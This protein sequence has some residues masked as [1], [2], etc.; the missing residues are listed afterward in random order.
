MAGSVAEDKEMMDTNIEDVRKLQAVLEQE[1]EQVQED[2]DL[3]FNISDEDEESDGYESDSSLTTIEN[4]SE[5]KLHLAEEEYLAVDCLKISK[6]FNVIKPH[7]SSEE[8]NVINSCKNPKLKHLLVLNRAKNINLKSIL[9]KLY[10]SYKEVLGHITKL[11]EEAR[12][13]REEKQLY[14]GVPKNRMHHPYFYKSGMKYSC[15]LNED[16]KRRKITNHYL[17]NSS[18]RW[19]VQDQTI[20]KRAV[21]FQYNQYQ[22]KETNK[23]ISDLLRVKKEYKGSDV[24]KI[25]EKIND[26]KKEVETLKQN[27]NVSVPDLKNGIIDWLLISTQDLAGKHSSHGC[28]GMWNMFLHP[29][30]NKS[31]KWTDSENK[32]LNELA[33]AH[34]FQDW[35]TIAKELGTNRSAYTVCIQFREK[36]MNSVDVGRFDVDEDTQLIRAVNAYRIGNYIPWTKVAE[37]FSNRLKKQLYNRY[38]VY[39]NKTKC[40]KRGPFTLEEDILLLILVRKFGANYNTI[41]EYIPYR[42][43]IQVSYRYTSYLNYSVMK[44]GSWSLLEDNAIMQHVK[45]HGPKKWQL[46]V[47]EVP[48][49]NAAHF[50]H[51]YHHLNKWLESNKNKTIE[52]IPR[53]DETKKSTLNTT[54]IRK[55]A[56]MYKTSTTIPT[57][58][59]ITEKIRTN[60]VKPGRK[61]KVRYVNSMVD[62]EL[63]Q[64]FQSTHRLRTAKEIPGSNI[65][66]ICATVKSLL[67]IMRAVLV[68]PS[69]T[70]LNSISN[71]DSLDKQILTNVFQNV[72]AQH[73]QELNGPQKKVIKVEFKHFDSMI[74]PPNLN[75]L[76][77]MR[78]L[79]LNYERCKSKL[80]QTMNATSFTVA[81]NMIKNSLNAQINLCDPIVRN[82]IVSEQEEF[83][84]RLKSLFKWPAI[85]SGIQ[86]SVRTF[87]NRPQKQPPKRK[88]GRPKKDTTKIDL[89]FK[90]KLLKKELNKTSNKCNANESEPEACTDKLIETKGNQ[91]CIEIDDSNEQNV[92]TEQPKKKIKLECD[93]EKLREDIKKC[94]EVLLNELRKK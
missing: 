94:E 54:L 82:L 92:Y 15:T 19:T 87:T 59:E 35:D 29:S 70:E 31:A 6:S 4:I 52:N 28:E 20:L 64:Y 66:T 45:C 5:D 62:D 1:K 76:V 71:L 75:T 11:N 3:N 44:T 88:V 36:L 91:I 69:Q 24:N 17:T 21:C 12:V 78:G 85:M 84:F 93:N 39:L 53:K 50:R 22:I 63:I 8:I 83:A 25:M 49:R 32:K 42:S 47:E 38:T 43:K 56:D 65:T 72:Y 30:I 90:A 16:A 61:A 27:E 18:G 41:C 13:K 68:V 34:E 14:K 23:K 40:Q 10:M 51:R 37:H 67:A 9:Y 81:K 77:G 26:L 2:F 80:T 79:L 89:M 60:G 7:L 73:S 58:K 46:L 48:T 33:E 57:L 86:P 55:I 74:L